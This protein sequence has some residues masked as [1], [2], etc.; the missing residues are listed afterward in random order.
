MMIEV[1]CLLLSVVA[2][3]VCCL[4][5]FAVWAQVLCVVWR[6]CLL[7]VGNWL[8]YV[9]RC[10]LFVVGCWCSVVD[11]CCLLCVVCRLL[12]VVCCLSDCVR[13]SLCV[14]C[15][16]LLIVCCLL[17]GVCGLLLVV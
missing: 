13:C 12:C 14:A 8:L 1:R 11:V 17:V 4:L 9:V 15:R 10:L 7:F 16:S 3:V 5:V 2:D 6:C